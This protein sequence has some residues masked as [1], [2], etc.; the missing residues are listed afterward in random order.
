[1]TRL[2]TFLIVLVAWTAIPA[3]TA[4]AQEAAAPAAVA[5][6]AEAADRAA[7]LAVLSREDVRRAA[8]IADVDLDAAASAVGSL[9]GERL[10][11]AA[12]QART[13]ESRLGAQPDDVLNI[14]TTTLIIV[15]LLIVII[16]VVA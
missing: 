10:T 2:H 3:S 5:V 12:D 4:L 7:V 13:L 9:E 6:D 16:I 1:M 15:L 8:R 14:T 11:R